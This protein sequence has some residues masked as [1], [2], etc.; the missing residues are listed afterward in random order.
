VVEIDGLLMSAEGVLVL[1]I[2]DASLI[3]MSGNK[4]IV[5]ESKEVTDT[6]LQKPDWRSV[7]ALHFNEEA[8]S[9]L[10]MYTFE[11]AHG[12]Q[13]LCDAVIWL[14]HMRFFI[15]KYWPGNIDPATNVS[16]E[17]SFRLQQLLKYELP[18]QHEAYMDTVTGPVMNNNFYSEKGCIQRQKNLSEMHKLLALA[19]PVI[20]VWYEVYAKTSHPSKAP[21]SVPSV[22]PSK[23]P[24]SIPLKFGLLDY[25]GV[26]R[27]HMV[28]A[29]A[30]LEKYLQEGGMGTMRLKEAGNSTDTEQAEMRSLLV[31]LTQRYGGV[32]RDSLASLGAPLGVTEQ[33]DQ[34]EVPVAYRDIVLKEKYQNLS[35]NFTIRV[36]ENESLFDKL[37]QRRPFHYWIRINSDYPELRWRFESPAGAEQTEQ[38]TRDHIDL[39]KQQLFRL[40]QGG[41]PPVLKLTHTDPTFISMFQ[42]RPKPRVRDAGADKP[43][44]RH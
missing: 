3:N 37:D 17:D 10:R 8:L 29:L 32:M 16:W 14:E 36:Y 23:V 13:M 40:P 9:V 6:R 22:D 1:D 12:Y 42:S 27:D 43:K 28:P 19:D 21:E 38:R 39:W 5:K 11:Y 31:R 2:K 4:D 41:D 44:R 7:C 15:A 34:D 35:V 18:G 33:V 25:Y 24:E 30:W 26:Y 20:H